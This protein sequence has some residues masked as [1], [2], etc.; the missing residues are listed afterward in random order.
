M[1]KPRLFLC[2]GVTLPPAD[3]LLQGRVVVELSTQGAE[4]NVH[5]RLEDVAT[6][7]MEDL[8][9]RLVDLLEI[10]AYVYTAD[11]ATARGGE[12]ADD[13]TTEPWDRDFQF[14]VPVRDVTFWLRADVGKLL[15]QVLKFLSDDKYA[16][17]FKKLTHEPAK[18]GYLAFGGLADW[19]FHGVDRVLMFSC[20]L[21]S[22]AGAVET[23]AAGGRLVLVSHRPVTTQNRRQRELFKA[24]RD[25]SKAE[26]IHIPVWVNKEKSKG[27]EHTQRTRS[28][29]YS[30]LGTVVA[31]S[32]KAGGIRFFENGVVSLNLPV[33]NEALRAR[34]S[35]TTHPVAL[36]LFSQLYGQVTGRPF[37]VD[38]PYLFKT[39]AEVISAVA[40][41]GRADL[42]KLTCSCAHGIFKPKGQ[43]HC[44]TCS[45]CID[46]R[47][48]V[49]AA[50]QEAHDPADDYAC[51]V[52]TGPR[53]DGYEKNMAVNYARHAIE[54]NRISEAEMAARFNQELSRAVRYSARPGEDAR[55]L[56]ELHQRHGKAVH[57][58]L[59]RQLREHAGSLLDGSLDPSSML[60]AVAGQQHK[61]S[62][63]KRFAGRIVAILQAGLPTACKTTK[64][65]DEPRLQEICDGI[66]KGHDL[67]LI[68]EFPFMRWG[69]SLTKPDWSAEELVLWVE[70][71]YVRKKPD[72]NKISEAIAADIVKYGDNQRRVLF[73]VYDPAHLV[74][75]ERSF[76][77]PVVKREEMQLEFIR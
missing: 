54:L 18:T 63:W 35:R 6:Q 71:K 22:L 42:I 69:S 56:I 73:L 36:E 7:F 20:G 60:V 25:V 2:S 9:P 75:D 10:A 8:S 72:I 15:T 43:W 24:L 12:W 14:V 33:A 16:F 58:V 29:L 70:L 55:K 44:G 61:I 74:T 34:A 45:Q 32:V 30:A 38:N 40:S 37:N 48:A 62:T 41:H 31:E 77:E 39:K 13:G 51:D 26:M 19:P 11:C 67:N 28:F 65:K 27:R 66:L 1:I 49:I 76:A 53:K 17:H 59:L 50:G 52:F 21:D 4:A 23:A 47:V 3:P 5:L 57:D 46:R 64:P 68:R